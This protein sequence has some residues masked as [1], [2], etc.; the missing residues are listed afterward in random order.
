VILRTLPHE[1]GWRWIGYHLAK[2][3]HQVELAT[4]LLDLDWLRAKLE[5]ADIEA[6]V[7]E[8][9]HAPDRASL[10][11]MQG[12]LRLSAHVLAKSKSQLAGQL[13]GRIP[14]GELSLRRSILERALAHPKPWL[15]PLH[16]TLT[17]PGGPLLRTLE[18]HAGVVYAV[19]VTPDGKRAV[20]G[21]YDGTLKVW[22][23]ATGEPVVSFSADAGVLACAIAPEPV[24]LVAADGGGSVHFFRLENFS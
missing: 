21:S 5:A 8:F 2:A 24:T 13:L 19:A 16:P 23:V 15:R 4:L 14:E 7:R 10:R 1:Y 6:L 20:S 17:N 11:L 18:G 12:A 3:G 9:D 22:E